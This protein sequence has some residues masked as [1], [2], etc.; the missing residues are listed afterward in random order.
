MYYM[1]K[2]AIFHEKMWE[3]FCS[4]KAPTKTITTI[5]VITITVCPSVCLPVSP[6]VLSKNLYNQLLSQFLSNQSE[7]LH[8]FA[9]MLKMCTFLFEKENIIYDKIKA[10]SILEIFWLWLI[11][12]L[13]TSTLSRGSYSYLIKGNYLFCIV[14][15]SYCYCVNYDVTNVIATTS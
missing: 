3:A 14:Y 10:F 5:T 1:Q 12:V 8:N 11:Q 7:T 9:D 6:S 4:A 2:T 15:M 13:M